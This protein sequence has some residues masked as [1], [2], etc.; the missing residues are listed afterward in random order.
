FVAAD[1]LI[2]IEK[3]NGLLVNLVL[4]KEIKEKE[5]EIHSVREKHFRARTPDTKE[6]YRLLDAQH[7]DELAKLLEKDGFPKAATKQLA[8][9]NPY[10]QNKFANFFD[11]MWMFEIDNGFNIVIGNPPYGIKFSSAEKEYLRKNFP[12]LE[13]KI[14]SYEAFILK[15]IKLLAPYGI[16]T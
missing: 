15:S 16:C 3:P 14:D 9:W 4:E 11:P 7:R 12:E 13:F 5:D 8:G 6:K 2:S 10:D 1:T